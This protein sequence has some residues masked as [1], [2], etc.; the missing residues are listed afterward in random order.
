MKLLSK[1]A[2]AA[3]V[4]LSQTHVMRLVEGKKFPQPVKLGDFLN[5]KIAFLEFEIDE[6][7]LDRLAKRS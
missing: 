6:W 7:I 2:T 5:S 4:S 3:K 1:K